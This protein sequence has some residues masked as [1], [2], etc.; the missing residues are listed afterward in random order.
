MP[1]IKQEKRPP[2]SAIADTMLVEATVNGEV[3]EMTIKA[4]INLFVH[5]PL[6]EQ[7]GDLNY[8]ITYMFKRLGLHKLP[9]N[10]DETQA[11]PIIEAIEK[12]LYSQEV[13]PQKYFHYNRATGMLHSCREEF[14]RR[15]GDTLCS[16]LLF[17]IGKNFYRGDVGPYEV[18]KIA[19][20]GDV[21]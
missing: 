5:A 4:A 19:E 13:Y 21:P 15:Y 18:T 10:S 2:F 7:D 8:T 17:R 14:E 12:I 6:E 1:Y 20:N 16:T 11:K 9:P 3:S